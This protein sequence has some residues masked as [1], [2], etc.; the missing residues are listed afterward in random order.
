MIYKTDFEDL[1]TQVMITS[2]Y[3]YPDKR[4]LISFFT[5]WDRKLLSWWGD[6]THNKEPNQV[7]LTIQSEQSQ[8]LMCPK[9]NS[10][11]EKYDFILFFYQK[12]SVLRLI[13]SLKDIRSD[14]TFR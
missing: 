9:E 5:I 10:K 14:K 13:P 1:L 12:R 3:Y 4:W 8:I 6:W 7:P 11:K 2:D